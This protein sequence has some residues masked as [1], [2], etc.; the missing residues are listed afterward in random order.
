[1]TDDQLLFESNSNRTQDSVK[2]QLLSYLKGIK[3]SKGVDD[4]QVGEMKTVH[5]TWTKLYP[6]LKDRLLAIVASKLF[7]KVDHE[8]KW[9]HTV[10]PYTI[11]YGTHVNWA[12]IYNSL[13]KTVNWSKVE[14][15]LSPDEDDAVE[16]E[17]LSEILEIEDIIVSYP[18]F[19]TPY[20]KDKLVCPYSIEE[21]DVFIKPVMPVKFI[22]LSCVITPDGAQFT[23]T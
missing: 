20:Y 14:E 4:Y 3:M 23:S 19:L 9:Y 21:M 22:N 6:K 17:S 10:F 2:Q 11:T 18:E 5:Y 8:P 13:N 15:R 16:P 7:S 1:M 12:G